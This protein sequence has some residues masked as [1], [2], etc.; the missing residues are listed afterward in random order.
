MDLARNLKKILLSL[1]N[2]ISVET[3][4]PYTEQ[5]EKQTTK[6]QDNSL[7]TTS[8]QN[9]LTPEDQDGTIQMY[10]QDTSE[11]TTM[12]ATTEDI[13]SHIRKWSIGRV[14]DKSVLREDARAVLEEFYEWIEPEDDEI[15]I[16]SIEPES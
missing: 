7:S 1:A 14:A 11:K 12:N 9:P 6:K 5:K 8:S 4:Y 3:S 15:K 10:C 16:L 2:K 13:V